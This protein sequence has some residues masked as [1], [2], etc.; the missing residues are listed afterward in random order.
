[1]NIN[2]FNSALI[3]IGPPGCG[4]SSVGKKLAE[5]LSIPF[6]DLDHML[7]ERYGVNIGEV[8]KYK[9]ESYFRVLETQC[10]EEFYR[11]KKSTVYVLSTGGGTVI[12][13]KNQTLLK[14]MGKLIYIKSSIKTILDRL[15]QDETVRPVYQNTSQEEF[16]FILNDRERYYKDADWIVD[17]EGLSIPQI[18]QELIGRLNHGTR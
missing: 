1:M 16:K 2:S 18:C 17:A 11:R 9:K 13:P 4:K 15:S 12:L 3:L 10:L 6:Y 5:K 14:K 7:E 8:F